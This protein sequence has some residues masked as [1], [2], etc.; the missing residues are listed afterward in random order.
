MVKT[1][2]RA[3]RQEIIDSHSDDKHLNSNL[4]VEKKRNPP[5]KNENY[6]TEKIS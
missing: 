3:Y 6:V 2:N 4:N 5:Q 1:S